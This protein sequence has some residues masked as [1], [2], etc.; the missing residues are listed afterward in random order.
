MYV[1][2]QFNT[3]KNPT[4]VAWL[5]IAP[6]GGILY[7]ADSGNHVIRSFNP[8]T[9]FLSTVAGTLGG[10]GYANGSASTARFNYP[11]GI[12]G[13]APRLWG[14]QTGCSQYNSWGV[15]IQPLIS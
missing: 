12:T 11:T 14:G 6:S 4:G 5:A 3:L 8:S 15:C 7:I 13:E 10:A 2:Y 1:T 9:G